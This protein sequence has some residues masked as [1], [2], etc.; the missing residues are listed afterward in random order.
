[1]AERDDRDPAEEV[2]VAAAVDVGEP[3]A[4]AGDERDVVSRVGGQ[5]RLPWRASAVMPSTAVAP[6]AASTPSRAA[7]TA[8]RSFGTMPPRERALREQPLGLVDADR[9]RD[10]SA[11]QEPRDVGDEE[12]PVGAEPDRERGGGLVRVDVQRPDGERRDDRDEAGGERVLDRSRRARERRADE[13][14]LRDT[15]GVEPDLVAEERHRDAAR[16]RR[17][18]RR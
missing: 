2:E 17:R 18:P 8:A 15:R 13:A 9:L 6:I 14:E 5:E 11:E 12:E 1:M 4:L 10:S 16:A 7:P 3:D